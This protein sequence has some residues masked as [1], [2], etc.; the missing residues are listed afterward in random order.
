MDCNQKFIN[1]ES[2]KPFTKSAQLVRILGL[3]LSLTACSST[4]STISKSENPA[5]KINLG[6]A[7]GKDGENFSPSFSPDGRNVVFISQK[8]LSHTQSQVYLLN[9]D[10]M[11]EKRV[12][13]QDGQC[14]SPLFSADGKKIIY[15]SDTDERKERLSILNPDSQSEVWPPSEI[16]EQNIDGT[17][18]DRLTNKEGFD[19]FPSLGDDDWLYYERWG[20]K[21]LEVWKLNTKTKS[22][23]PLLKNAEKSIESFHYSLTEKKTA[24]I[25]R[26]PS[27]QAKIF[28]SKSPLKLPAGD[29]KDLTWWGKK[30]VFVSNAF[31]KK[32]KIYTYT[33][34]ND[35]LELLQEA[36]GNLS[37]P[38]MHPTRDALVFTSSAQ[39]KKQIFY[40]IITV[41]TD[42][43]CL[44]KTVTS[45]NPP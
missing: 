43:V 31:D 19:G 10:R 7:L 18:I 16:Y 38:K 24:W 3:T 30:I 13:Y 42:P 44:N 36:D 37:E 41:S 25:E 11:S 21:N 4:P 17:E 6:I 8:R 26:D 23:F 29:Y 39:G 5:D 22:T 14:S 1:G 28:I 20:G 45:Q 34:Q 2:F 32:F 35:C 40:K 12:T 33:L 9:L 15:A 27:N